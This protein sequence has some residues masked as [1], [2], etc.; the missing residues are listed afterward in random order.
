MVTGSTPSL[1][2]A[3]FPALSTVAVRVWSVA[4]TWAAACCASTLVTCQPSHRGGEQRAVP[5]HLHGQAGG[6]SLD[7]TNVEHHG[8]SRGETVDPALQRI[9]LAHL[10][11]QALGNLLG[12]VI[13]CC[14]CVDDLDSHGLDQSG[15]GL[16]QADAEPSLRARATEVAQGGQ[17]GG[18]QLADFEGTPG[19]D[20]LCRTQVQ[21]GQQLLQHV[22][23][24]HLHSAAGPQGLG[25]AEPE[26]LLFS[27]PCYVGAAAL[28]LK[29]G[30]GQ[31]HG[32][33]LITRA[34]ALPARPGGIEEFL[35]QLPQTLLLLLVL[36]EPVPAVLSHA[37][38][39]P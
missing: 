12:H 34:R 3:H 25:H 1:R 32:R 7:R 29:E 18:E 24:D 22:P 21:L 38:A 15:F 39:A 8:V 33:P 16:D 17:P 9:G 13:E 36:R 26:K 20:Q 27:C 10:G 11:E 37:A 31:G 35:H 28:H 2:R 30:N 19:L 4:S 5:E 23:L 14:G 6:D